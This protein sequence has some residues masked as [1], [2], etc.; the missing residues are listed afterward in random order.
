MHEDGGPDEHCRDDQ[1]ER[2][3]AAGVL[4]SLGERVQAA[5]FE[6]D[7]QLVSTKL[8][9][10]GT[11]LAWEHLDEFGVS[12][13][14]A[15]EALSQGGRGVPLLHEGFDIGTGEGDE[16]ELGVQAVGDGLDGGQGLDQED[17]VGRAVDVI[18][19]ELAEEVLEQAAQVQAVQRRVVEVRDDGLNISAEAA[20]FELFG[21]DISKCADDGDD[22]LDIS[23]DDTGD[24]VGELLSGAW[25]ELAGHAAVDEGDRSAG[26]GEEI[27]RVWICVE[28]A[29]F[30]ALA[31]DGAGAVFNHLAAL[32]GA[33]LAILE[34]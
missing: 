25:V 6:I 15:P 14:A 18:G 12:E 28:V 19:A 9:E 20:V 13:Q 33:N 10:K 16:L 23:A 30:Q 24:Q 3:V 27:A 5:M 29:D 4:N 2:D 1:R 26:Q 7:R 34:A 11:D 8:S 31:E 21:L 22:L 17:E 32:V